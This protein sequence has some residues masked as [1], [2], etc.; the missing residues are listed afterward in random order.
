[1]TGGRSSVANCPS[2]TTT[3]PFTTVYA[4][5]DGAQNTSAAT[6][7][8]SAPANSGWRRSNAAKSAAMPG[9]NAPM[10]SR[11]STC[12]PPSVAISSA[13]RAV[14][15]SGPK[16][17]RCSSSACRTSA[18]ICA[19]SFDAE[20][21]TPSPT[22][23]PASRIFFTGAMPDASRMF[24]HGQCATPVPVRANRPMPA[25]S[26]C[27]QCACQTS[28]PTQPRSSAY[29]AG[30]IPNFSRLYA[31]SLTFSA[32]WVCSDTRYSRASRAA[33]R[34]SSR[35][36]ENGEHGATTTRSIA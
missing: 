28:C 15:A 33:S 24:E 19:P 23:T 26:S 16:P 31:M 18:T 13:S 9:F 35:L 8:C 1:M 27:T 3:F 29:S 36:T 4:A 20:P 10:S 25:S 34:I 11:F 22:G 12:A 2:R 30:V 5:C 17:T 32:R 21:S 7:S 6:G 14:I